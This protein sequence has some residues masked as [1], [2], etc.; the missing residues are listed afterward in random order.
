MLGR[1]DESH[2]GARC[3]SPSSTE[4]CARPAHEAAVVWGFEMQGDS[5]TLDLTLVVAS[6]W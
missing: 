2:E 4:P 1:G 5:K 6:F 3:E